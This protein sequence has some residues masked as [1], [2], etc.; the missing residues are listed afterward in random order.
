MFWIDN[1]FITECHFVS[2]IF[3]MITNIELTELSSGTTLMSDFHVK[4]V[5]MADPTKRD[6]GNATIFYSGKYE[7]YK[8]KVNMKNGKKEGKGVIYRENNIVFMELCFVND[9]AEGELTERNR[10]GRII[11]KGCLHEG[12]KSGLFIEFDDKGLELSRR[13]YRNGLLISDLKKSEQIDGYYDEIDANGNTLS[14]SQYTADRTHKEGICY[15]YENG[16]CSKK[17]QYKNDER[18]L[19]MSEFKGDIMIEYD[20]K[21]KR[22]YQGGYVLDKTNGYLRNGEGSEYMNDGESALYIGHFEKGMRSGEGTSY[23]DGYPQYVGEWKNG[24]KNGQGKE[25]DKNGNIVKQGTWN[26]GTNSSDCNNVILGVAISYIFLIGLG[27][28]V[29]V[30]LA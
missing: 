16:V 4:S 6:E 5:E 19:L 12:R 24:L 14:T 7:G 28:L 3:I 18:L 23:C 25:Y 30:S 13:F 26:N 27:L 9:I 17:Y 15:E 29:V 22:V 2:I 20:D 1:E 21:G 11:R 10:L 8:M